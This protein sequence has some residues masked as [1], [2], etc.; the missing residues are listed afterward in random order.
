MAKAKPDAVDQM[1]RLPERIYLRGRL[2]PDL[3][4]AIV[5]SYSTV[6]P[7]TEAFEGTDGYKLELL[8]DQGKV[9]NEGPVRVWSKQRDG[10]EF[11][12]LAVE[13]RIVLR[14]DADTLRFSKGDIVIRHLD[15]GES[16]ELSVS[17]PKR[18]SRDSESTLKI[19]F[20]KPGEG[21]YVQVGYA[22]GAQARILGFFEPSKSIS[23][24]LRDVPGG[25]PAQLSV[26]YC[27]G[28]R[29][30]AVASEQFEISTKEPSVVIHRPQPDERFLTTQPVELEGWAIDSADRLVEDGLRWTV[31]GGDFRAEYADSVVAIDDELPEGE[32]RA[33]LTFGEAASDVVF[34]VGE[35]PA[36]QNQQAD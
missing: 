26:H 17:F 16:P 9:V 2:Y 33:V 19:K 22:S 25:E 29:S 21:A 27:N 15:I 11:A 5:R 34:L 35:Y 28:L 31:E 18:F 3:E 8:D 24:S 13:G 7:E 32:Y 23:V 30:V 6:A 12:W 4:F 10:E 14:G 20:S 36:D 1:R